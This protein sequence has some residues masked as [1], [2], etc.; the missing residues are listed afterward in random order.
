M[1]GHLGRKLALA[2]QVRGIFGLPGIWTREE[3]HAGLCPSL[4][5]SRG[6]WIVHHANLGPIHGRIVV[7]VQY[8]QATS[9]NNN[10]DD[11]DGLRPSH[12]L[13]RC[14]SKLRARTMQSSQ[15]FNDQRTKHSY[16]PVRLDVQQLYWIVPPLIVLCVTLLPV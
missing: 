11:I 9:N 4:G 1:G 3:E 5:A 13:T 7:Y 6:R 8:V 2:A 10:S 12:H 14:F 16:G 15:V